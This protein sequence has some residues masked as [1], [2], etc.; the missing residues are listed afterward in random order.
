[1]LNKFIKRGNK[2][3]LRIFLED[4]SSE[5]SSVIFG[6]K[7]RLVDTGAVLAVNKFPFSDEVDE[8]NFEP[9]FDSTCDC[10]ILLLS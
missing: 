5:F 6:T 8:D 9:K 3:I 1:M 4:K 2:I 10:I 7:D